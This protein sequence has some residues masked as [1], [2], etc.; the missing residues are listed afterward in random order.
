MREAAQTYHEQVRGDVV[1][2]WNQRYLPP[3]SFAISPAPS[4]HQCA[5][6]E[7]MKNCVSVLDRK[8]SELVKI[9]LVVPITRA[10][11]ASR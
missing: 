6:L 9:V 3:H 11:P 1:R 8:H 7:A 4:Q 10:A 2:V 5:W